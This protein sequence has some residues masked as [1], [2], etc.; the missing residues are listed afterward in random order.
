MT[1]AW[2]PSREILTYHES[3]STAN[4]ANTRGASRA[5]YL[6]VKDHCQ[7]KD[8]P[9]SSASPWLV[10]HFLLSLWGVQLPRLHVEQGQQ[11]KM[12][13]RDLCKRDFTASTTLCYLFF[14]LS[15]MLLKSKEGG[16]IADL[17]A[18]LWPRQCKQQRAVVHWGSWQA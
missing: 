1:L 8:A 9:R 10:P 11:R 17:L 4:L 14:S 15:S 5:S 6:P 12:S 3:Q 2:D 7:S 16:S 13:L 18:L